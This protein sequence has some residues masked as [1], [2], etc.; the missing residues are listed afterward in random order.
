[1]P[2]S[3]KVYIIDDDP[4]MRDSLDFLLGTAGFDVALFEFRRSFPRRACE[5]RGR[6]H[7]HGCAHAGHG[8]HRTAAP[9]EIGGASRFR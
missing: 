9:T 4:A 6:L 7:G 5:A 1:M 2:Q 3:G 8:R